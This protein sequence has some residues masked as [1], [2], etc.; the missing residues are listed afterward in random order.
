AA[1]GGREEMLARL[2]AVVRTLPRP[3]PVWQAYGRLT[4]AELCRAEGRPSPE[5]WA[6]A[7]A[8]LRRVERPYE[9]AWACHRWAEALL[10]CGPAAREQREAA[11]ALLAEARAA[12]RWMGADPLALEIDRLALRARIILPEGRRSG[13]LTSVPAQSA[14]AL[15]GP[16]R[17]GPAGDRTAET[18]VATADATTGATADT[19]TGATAD[20]L[21]LTPRE[22]DVLR[23]VAVGRS[24]RQIADALFISP[25]T[26][27]VHVSNILAKLGVSGRGE[28]GAL[29]HRL[30]LFPDAESA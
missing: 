3:V 9:L 6:E 25:K 11:T 1:A 20:S 7:V 12:A 29:A 14:P 10:T 2:A 22:Q 27:S 30:R 28:A 18:T 19:R 24:N 13:G 8:A 5:R 23:L 15:T 16:V 17:A 26:A 21:G 4:E